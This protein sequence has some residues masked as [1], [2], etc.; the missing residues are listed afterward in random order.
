MQVPSVHAGT[1]SA[2]EPRGLGQDELRIRGRVA[3]MDP[4][5][6]QWL[7]DTGGATQEC[8]PIPQVP[9][10]EVDKGG[11]ESARRLEGAALTTTFEEPPASDPLSQAAQ[12]LVR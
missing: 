10:G 1:I 2:V 12:Q 6:D 7:A 9:V 8:E 3:E 5:A 4:I 11:I